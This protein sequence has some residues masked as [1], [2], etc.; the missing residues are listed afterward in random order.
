MV[1]TDL[2]DPYGDSAY[3]GRRISEPYFRSPN[4]IYLRFSDKQA[5]GFL[6]NNLTSRFRSGWSLFVNKT[7]PYTFL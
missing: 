6:L 1:M 5:N 7:K 4:L 3:A 2:G